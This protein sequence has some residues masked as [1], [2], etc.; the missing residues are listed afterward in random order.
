MEG[1]CTGAMSI[2]ISRSVGRGGAKV[3]WLRVRRQPQRRP[4]RPSP[5]PRAPS[6]T[7][8]RWKEGKE[9]EG[10]WKHWHASFGLLYPFLP[11]CAVSL[12]LLAV[13]ALSLCGEEETARFHRS[14]API[15]H[16]MEDGVGDRESGETDATRREGAACVCGGQ[17]VSPAGGAGQWSQCGAGKDQLGRG[18]AAAEAVNAGRSS[19]F[20]VPSSHSCSVSSH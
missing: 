3:W 18:G 6:Q 19:G 16:E 12:F 15:L 7:N 11:A 9:I 2:A 20:R 10:G 17:Q 1:R 5:L 4:K 8:R 14:P 13:I